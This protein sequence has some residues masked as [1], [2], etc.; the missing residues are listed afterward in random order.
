MTRWPPVDSSAARAEPITPL[1]PVIA[2]VSGSGQVSRTRACTARSAAS[3]RCRYPN[4]GRSAR[5]GMGVSTESM[6]SVPPPGA[7]ANWWVC[8]QR[9]AVPSGGRSTSANCRGGS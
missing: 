1:D 6:T 5:A 9:S 7:G 3:C 4:I 2:T 8:R